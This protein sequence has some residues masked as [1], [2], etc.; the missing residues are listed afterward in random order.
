MKQFNFNQAYEAIVKASIEQ[1]KKEIPLLLD[2]T[3]F[4]NKEC[5]E[6]GAGPLA[7]LA[8]KLLKSKT[9]PKHI[10]C[11]DP[12]NSEKIKQIAKK[13]NLEEEISVTK[14]KSP[15]K[16]SFDKNS[17]DIVYAAWIP[18][19][20]L[21]NPK[22][23]NELTRVSKKDIIIIM[24][25]LKGDIPKIKDLILNKNE[26]QKKQ[27]LKDFLTNHFKKRGFKVDTSNQTTLKLNFPNLDTLFNTFYFFDFKNKLSQKDQDKLK[28]YLKPKVHNFKDNLYIFHAKKK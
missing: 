15:L 28:K 20:L 6:I 12:W 26:K 13:K 8:V 23:L 21:K 10:T 17:F 4:K 25:G 9:P 22:Y 19:D 3:D 18:T 24:S 14:P 16:L 27:E 7:R 5:L 11:L 2:S 1:D